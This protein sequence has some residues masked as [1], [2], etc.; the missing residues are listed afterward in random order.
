MNVRCA[1]NLLLFLSGTGGE[2]TDNVHQIDGDV[3]GAGGWLQE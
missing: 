3:W 1:Q 2:N